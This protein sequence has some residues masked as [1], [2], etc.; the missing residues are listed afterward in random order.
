MESIA[1]CYSSW[2]PVISGQVE[3]T[4]LLRTKKRR[5]ILHGILR[6]EFYCTPNYRT[7]NCCDTCA[8]LNIGCWRQKILPKHTYASIHLRAS[9]LMSSS[10]PYT[11]QLL[12]KVGESSNSQSIYTIPPIVPPVEGGDLHGLCSVSECDAPHLIPFL[13]F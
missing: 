7:V 11:A 2:T 13:S 4:S 5:R 10:Y 3:S 6:V 12:D 8:S 9:V 1:S